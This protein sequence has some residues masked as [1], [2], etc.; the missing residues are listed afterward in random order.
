MCEMDDPFVEQIIERLAAEHSEGVPRVRRYCESGI[1]KM[2]EE[3]ASEEKIYQ[4]MS[5]RVK[6][7]PPSKG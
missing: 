5:R 6:D 3:G 2:K 4:E 7:L 1:M